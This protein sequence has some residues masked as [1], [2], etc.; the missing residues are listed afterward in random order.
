M[1]HGFENIQIHYCELSKPK[2]GS[3]VRPIGHTAL[4]K[5][6]GIGALELGLCGQTDLALTLGD[7]CLA[8][9]GPFVP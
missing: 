4:Q 8:A 6:K 3:A 7:D 2:L 5:R 1:P 9:F